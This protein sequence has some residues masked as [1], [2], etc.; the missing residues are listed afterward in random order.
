[1]TILQAGDQLLVFERTSGGE[2]LRCTFNLSDRPASYRP[3]GTPLIAAGD[4]DGSSLGP[5][6][7]VVEEIA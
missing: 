5:Y 1:M 6:A 7:A 4:I 2:T 3:S